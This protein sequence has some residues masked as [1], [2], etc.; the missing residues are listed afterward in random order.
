MRLI[1]F[2]ETAARKLA[3]DILARRADASCSEDDSRVTL[4][5]VVG[6]TYMLG[7]PDDLMLAEEFITDSPGWRAML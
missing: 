2:T 6:L 5:M 4:G 7:R 3:D 1:D